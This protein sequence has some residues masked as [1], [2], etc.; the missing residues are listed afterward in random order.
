MLKRKGARWLTAQVNSMPSSGYPTRG[1]RRTSVFDQHVESWTAAEHF[2]GQVAHC[3][4]GRQVS[5]K[6]VDPGRT[7]PLWFVFV[8]AALFPL[9]FAFVTDW[10]GEGEWNAAV[11][12]GVSAVVAIG[13]GPVLVARFAR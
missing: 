13:L 3:R 2:G 12:G 4:V 7:W 10:M 8:D 9:T 11:A 6:R 5:D 1:V